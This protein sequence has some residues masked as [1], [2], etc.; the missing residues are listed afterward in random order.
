MLLALFLPAG[1]QAAASTVPLLSDRPAEADLMEGGGHLYSVEVPGD[2]YV[3]LLVQQQGIDLAVKVSSPSGETVVDVDSPTGRTSTETVSFIAVEGGGLHSVEVRALPG[4]ARGRYRI[5]IAALRPATEED[6]RRVQAERDLLSAYRA[7]AR[8]NPEG[9]ALAGTSYTSALER[10]RSLG[11]LSGQAW[12]LQRIGMLH[13][14]QGNPREALPVL[15]DAL[16]HYRQI[17]SEPA[18]EAAVLNRLGET[19]ALLGDSSGALEMQLQALELFQRIGDR[20]QTAVVLTHLGG[21]HDSGGRLVEAR[22]AYE[23]AHLTARAVSDRS[24]EAAALNGMA[25]VEGRLGLPHERLEHLTAALALYREMH[26]AAAEAAVLINLGSLLVDLHAPEAAREILLQALSIQ[27]SPRNKGFAL[28]SLAWAAIG[29]DQPREAGDLAE[30]ALTLARET[31]D[32][33]IEALSLEALGAARLKAGDLAA[34]ET[35]LTQAL[36]IFQQLGRIVRV[37]SAQ[38]LL[39]QAQATRGAADAARAS[40]ERSLSLANRI[41]RVDIEPQILAEIARL[42]RERN[43]E[44]AHRRIT[45]ALERHE[46]FR[47]RL[48][49]EGLRRSHFTSVHEAYG[50]YVD[51]LMRLERQQPGKGFGARALEAAEQ[52][53]ARSLLELLEQARIDVREGD[54]ALLAEEERL[55]FELNSLGYKRSKLSP[56]ESPE[57]AQ[58]VRKRI[59]STAAELQIL[60]ARL[61]AG[62]ARYSALRRPDLRVSEIQALL[63]GET[64]L[65]EYALGEPRSYLWLVTPESLSFFELPGRG[66]IEALARRVHEHLRSPNPSA[67]EREDLARLGQLLLAP[68]LDRLTGQRM[69]VVPDGALQY[70]PFS[71]LPVP[72]GDG[73]GT[74]PLI[75]RHEA[76]TLPSA[77][78]LREIRRAHAERERLPAGVAILADPVY[79]GIDPRVRRA[80]APAP[81]PADPVADALR[82]LRD[83]VREGLERLSWSRREAEQIAAAA[84]GRDVLLALGFEATRDLAASPGLGRYR[85]LHFATHGFLDTAHPELSGLAFSQVDEHGNLLDGFLR[86]QD[87]YRLRLNADLVVLSGC[88]TALGKHLRGEGLVGLSHGFLHAGA[89]QVVSS[90]WPVRDRATAELMER[91]YR[92]MFKDGLRAPAALRQ[93]QIEMWN[94]RQWRDPYYWAAFVAQGDWLAGAP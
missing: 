40:L 14:R 41:G 38:E 58:E 4:E 83:P 22:K 64:V 93:A 33:E 68:V 84:T 74:V 48:P 36:D 88:E 7:E 8:R 55:R 18:R 63:D 47:S 11:D 3:R 46:R 69:V 51:I 77:A 27:G 20:R 28:L 25:T 65:L 24:L 56:E 5:E 80:A 54:P 52:S 44:E 34:A 70:L 9:F 29:A 76:V 91:F 57:E 37:I 60:D 35:S 86:L 12:A 53:R 49:G 61:Q 89:S 2:G 32:R 10:W 81:P 85:I 45:A 43:P 59:D 79:D 21:L 66:E 71:A 75:V 39:G 73:A 92:A 23:S 87:V 19:L 50:L 6:R 26:N 30:S 67:T 94:Q 13:L 16:S 17:G 90:L 42:E 1:F 15:R 31:A 62:S 82:S 78:V 72:G